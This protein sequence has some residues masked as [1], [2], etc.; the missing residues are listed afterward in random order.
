MYLMFGNITVELI[1][2]LQDLLEAMITPTETQ[3]TCTETVIVVKQNF[4]CPALPS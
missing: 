4:A 1:L 2:R 3:R